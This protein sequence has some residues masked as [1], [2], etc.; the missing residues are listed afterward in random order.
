MMKKIGVLLLAVALLLLG[1]QAVLAGSDPATAE[2]LYNNTPVSGALVGNRGGAFAY[3]KIE[4][5]GDNRVVSVE[6]SVSP[7]DPAAMK[8]IVLKLYNASGSELGLAVPID[9][10]LAVP[11]GDTTQ[12]TWLVQ[13]GNYLHGTVVNYTLV[14]KGLPAAAAPTTAPVS[15][16]AAAPAPAP[17]IAGFPLSGTLT[18]DRAGAFVRADLGYAADGSNLVVSLNYT[19]ADPATAKGIGLTVY[20]PDG[21]SWQ[22]KPADGPGNLKATVNSDVPGKYEVVV[23][24]YI[25]GFT[26][27]YRVIR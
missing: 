13:V 17:A 6:L 18:G 25:H 19:P 4:Y 20:G 2:R 26:M 1:A 14:A 24:N 7:G 3:Y 9:K 15:A 5:P 27:D 10:G 22:A 23:W 12:G 21:R 16:P 11:Y 8:G